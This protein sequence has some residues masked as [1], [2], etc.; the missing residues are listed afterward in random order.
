V[1]HFRSALPLLFA[2]MLLASPLEAQQ[3]REVPARRLPRPEAA[4][5]ELRTMIEAGSMTTWND[6]PGTPEAWK[7]WVE[8]NAARAR[9]GLP[10]LRQKMDVSVKGGE[11]AGVKVFTITPGTISPENRNRALIHFHGGGYVLN[12]GE[13]GTS[14]AIMMA[15]FRHIQVISV[16]YRMSPDFPYPAAMDDAVAVYRAVI[17]DHDPARVG[18]FGTSTGGGMTLAL[19][20]RARAEGLPLPGA[21]AASTPWSDLEKKG[22]SYFAND[23]VDN[24]L[25]RYEGWLGDAARLYAH[26]HDMKDPFLSPIYGDFH[27]FPPT[28]LVSGTR[29]LFLSNT[30]RVHRKL[31]EAGVT[32][33]L[34][35]FEGLSHAQYL[36][37]PDMHEAKEYF[38]ELGAFFE[39]RLKG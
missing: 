5:P 7:R 20:L 32:A 31:R 17:A 35:V 34:V 16:D 28:I 15:G 12:P 18:V 36:F 25:V 6:H 27:G 33:D 14:E 29:D 23:T 8:Q 22:D 13:A 30:V 24:V 38:R 19:I 37:S 1:I 9:A 4:S 10:A 26:G 39:A 11:I 2:G 21:I 3:M